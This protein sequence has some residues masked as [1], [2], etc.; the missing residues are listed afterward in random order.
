[1]WNDVL[2]GAIWL[3]S[4]YNSSV[5]LLILWEVCSLQ[6]FAVL[7]IPFWLSENKCEIGAVWHW[8]RQVASCKVTTGSSKVSDGL[9]SFNSGSWSWSYI[10]GFLMLDCLWTASSLCCSGQHFCENKVLMFCVQGL[11]ASPVPL[12]R[13]QEVGAVLVSSWWVVLIPLVFLTIFVVQF[14]F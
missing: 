11:A 9:N 12:G 5:S 10:S 7:K 13:A 2:N 6:S 1:M 14:A 8:K 4:I 3:I